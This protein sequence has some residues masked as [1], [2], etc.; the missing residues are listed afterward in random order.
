MNESVTRRNIFFKAIFKTKQK[1]VSFIESIGGRDVIA[2]E[3]LEEMLISIDYPLEMAEDAVRYLKENCLSAKDA[4]P[5]LKEYFVRELTAMKAYK[6]PNEFTVILVVGVNGSGKTTTVAKMAHFFRKQGKKVL[7]CA[8]DT[9]RAAGSE[10][11]EV[12]AERLNLPVISQIKGAHPGAVVFD[13]IKKGISSEVDI[14]IA[15]TAGRLHSKTNLMEELKKV[16][17]SAEKAAEGHLIQTMLVLDAF[18]G[19]NALK[20]A[21][22][23][24]KALGVDYLVIT[25]A[26]GSAKGGACL[27]TSIKYKIPIAFVGFGES[28]EDIQ[29]FDPHEYVNELFTLET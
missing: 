22:E 11:L 27:G 16:S 4:L 1:I 29:L 17:K 5:V 20:Q 6:I 28:V 7:L 26:D 23:F 3:D 21:E 14:V 18:L 10:Q 15:D 24:N 12:W 2:F 9:Y 19:Q 25:K 13:S 8:G